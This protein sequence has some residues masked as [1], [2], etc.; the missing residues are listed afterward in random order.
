MMGVTT[1]RPLKFVS[2]CLL[3][4]RRF[5]L[6]SAPSTV[7]IQAMAGALTKLLIYTKIGAS[8]KLLSMQFPNTL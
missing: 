6:S 8:T 5:R 7:M 2:S 1:S 3:G 4:G